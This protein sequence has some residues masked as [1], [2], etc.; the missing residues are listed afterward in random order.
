MAVMQERDIMAFEYGSATWKISLWLNNDWGTYKMFRDAFH[1]GASAEDTFYDYFVDTL[2]GQS[3]AR[4]MFVD[5][6]GLVDWDEIESDIKGDDWELYE[7]PE[8]DDDE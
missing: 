2:P 8:E 3:M 6:L 5:L 7:G 1:N 4:D